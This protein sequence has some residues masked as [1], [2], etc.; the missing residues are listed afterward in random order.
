MAV[1]ENKKYI[2][3]DWLLDC[4]KDSLTNDLDK[5]KLTEWISTLT[6]IDEVDSYGLDLDKGFKIYM[7]VKAYEDDIEEDE[8]EDLEDE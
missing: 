7:N 8:E 2:V 6:E 3:S 5:T 1:Y 4:L